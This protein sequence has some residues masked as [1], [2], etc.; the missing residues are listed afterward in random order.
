M[1]YAFMLIIHD[2][3]ITEVNIFFDENITLNLVLTE[4]IIGSV[5]GSEEP[6]KRQTLYLTSHQSIITVK[7]K[8]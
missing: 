5:K 7:G 3:G 8:L 6:L 4:P 2:N 1:S